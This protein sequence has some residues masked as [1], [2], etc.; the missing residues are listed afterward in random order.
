MPPPVYSQRIFATGLLVSSVGRVGPVVPAGE[1]WILRDIDAV[2]FTG[3]RPASVFAYNQ[4]GGLMWS[5]AAQPSD[6]AG[7]FAWR[8]RQVYNEGE[9]V[10][11]SVGAG[12]WAIGASGYLLTAP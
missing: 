10:G 12:T 8:G 6:V 4:V 2:E 11:F 5:I 7:Y 9:Q 3:T 1:V